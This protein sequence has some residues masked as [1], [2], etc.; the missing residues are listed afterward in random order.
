ARS[1]RSVRP[2]PGFRHRERLHRTRL[3]HQ[4]T[5]LRGNA[6]TASSDD[7]RSASRS[8]RRKPA[9]LRGNA[10]TASSDDTRSAPRGERRKTT[11]A[12]HY[13]IAPAALGMTRQ[14][15]VDRLNRVGDVEILR[16]YAERDSISLPV[17]VVRL[18]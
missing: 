14:A 11:R 6:M 13:M 9:D 16:T 5:D 10:T 18:S 4:F 7:T 3:R 1:K 8:D 17:A 15:L 2:I 12:S